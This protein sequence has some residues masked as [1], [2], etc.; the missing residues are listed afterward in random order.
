[1]ARPDGFKAADL[2]GEPSDLECSAK[3][4]RI[5]I[6]WS[7]PE[8]WGSKEELA[9]IDESLK[10]PGYLYAISWGHH[11]AKQLET[12]AYIGITDNL[13]R[14]FNNHPTAD[15]LRAR[16]RKT[17]LS[18]GRIDFG[19]LSN[20]SERTRWITE[21]LEHLFIWTLWQTLVNERKMV[22]MPGFGTGGGHAWH[23]INEGHKFGG[24]MPSEIVYPWILEKP[25][26][27]KRRKT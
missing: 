6:E 15:K 17:F 5:T 3:Y 14:R 2:G 9:P 24:H 8:A 7:T 16:K 18:I 26:R 1:M 20:K 27:L 12:I 4:Q 10:K 25:R 21:Q 23:I 11:R 19:R 13:D 22:R